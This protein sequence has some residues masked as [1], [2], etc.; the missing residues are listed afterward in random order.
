MLSTVSLAWAPHFLDE[1]PQK[2]LSFLRL[3]TTMLLEP[4][5]INTTPILITPTQLPKLLISPHFDYIHLHVF[6]FINS[7]LTTC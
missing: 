4:L 2:L 3:K 6:G 1:V 7:N 5:T